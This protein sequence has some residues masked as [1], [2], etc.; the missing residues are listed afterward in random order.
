VFWKTRS[1]STSAR[2]KY[3]DGIRVLT[4]AGASSKVT[5]C[6]SAALSPA[7]MLSAGVVLLPRPRAARLIQRGNVFAQQLLEATATKLHPPPMSL[8]AYA[9]TFTLVIAAILALLIA[10]DVFMGF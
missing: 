2:G 8:P 9:F 3:R 1:I 10:A 4:A 6:G 5:A 7:M